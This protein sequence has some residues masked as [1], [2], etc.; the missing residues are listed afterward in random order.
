MLRVYCDGACRNNGKPN[1]SAGVGVVVYENDIEIE[2]IS[3]PVPIDEPQTNQRAELIALKE[4][5]LAIQRRQTTNAE[6]YSDSQY[7][8]KCTIEWGPVWR[9][10]GW[11]RPGGAIIQH[12]DLVQSLVSIFD[13]LRPQNATLHF[14]R[15]HQTA[16][17]RDANGNNRADFLATSAVQDR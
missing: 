16:S 17:H 9:A 5:L 11:K 12:L 15:A 8:M 6:I 4:A 2:T 1:A 3:F 7:A 13:S 14:V 10:K